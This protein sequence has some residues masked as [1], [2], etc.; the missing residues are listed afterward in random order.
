MKTITTKHKRETEKELKHEDIFLNGEYIGYIIKDNPLVNA[1]LEWHFVT[2]NYNNIPHFAAK[3]RK[4]LLIKI[5]EH[6]K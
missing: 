2:S 4:E 1:V 5:T 3:T 6:F